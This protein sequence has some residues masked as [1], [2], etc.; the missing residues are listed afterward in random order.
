MACCLLQLL[1]LCCFL[2]KPLLELDRF[3]GLSEM[4]QLDFIPVIFLYTSLGASLLFIAL[5]KGLAAMSLGFELWVSL[6]GKQLLPSCSPHG[7]GASADIT[8]A[9]P[10][11]GINLHEIRCSEALLTAKCEP[12]LFQEV[13]LVASGVPEA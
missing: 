5:F 13:C 11:R 7:V 2:W 10:F 6:S 3:P 8:S 4:P 12:G 9:S 1:A